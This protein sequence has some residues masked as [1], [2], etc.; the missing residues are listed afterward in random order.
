[1]KY[2]YPNGREAHEHAAVSGELFKSV[3]ADIAV[4]AAHE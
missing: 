2:K 3:F 4:F 1:M